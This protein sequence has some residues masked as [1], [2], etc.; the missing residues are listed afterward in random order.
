MLDGWQ[1]RCFIL[2]GDDR[3][4]DDQ[5]QN[6][7]LSLGLHL[8]LALRHVCVTLRL[9]WRFPVAIFHLVT[10]L[11]IRCNILDRKDWWWQNCCQWRFGS[12]TVD[13]VYNPGDRIVHLFYVGNPCSEQKNE[14]HLRLRT[15]FTAAPSGCYLE[16]TII[17][18]PDVVSI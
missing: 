3:H 1:W 11:L 13:R 6:V 12:V 4:F 16:C 7:Q 10:I 14:R 9:E 17:Y 18:G 15:V 8:H 2:W 5:G